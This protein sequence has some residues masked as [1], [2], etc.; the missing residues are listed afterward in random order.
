MSG[1]SILIALGGN[2]IS[3]EHEE[4]NIAQQFAH[5]RETM[6]ELVRAVH[7]CFDRIVIT[8]GNGPQIGNIVLRSEIAAPVLFP[9]PLDTCVSDSEGGMGYM[10]QQVLHNVLVERE[11]CRHVVSV[12]TQVVVSQ[13]DSHWTNPTK[14]IGK[15][16]T[17]EEAEERISERGWRM[18]RDGDRG[19]RRVVPSPDPLEVVEIEAIR[20]L[21]NRGIIV[22]AA[23]GGGIPVIREPDGRLRGVE[24]VVDKDLASSLLCRLLAIDSFVIVTGVDQVALHYGRPGEQFVEQ[25]TVNEAEQYMAAGHFPPGSMGPKIRAA[26]DYLRAGG[27]QV[28]ITSPGKLGRSLQGESGTTISPE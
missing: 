24:A 18:R 3:R 22:I 28:I 17:E 16:Y 11:I 9:L 4:G 27:R 23:G 25:M 5:T 10:I 21:L 2:A 26:I 15:F 19:W 1:K 14:Y 13:D 20:A 7:G 6:L 8:H 12:L